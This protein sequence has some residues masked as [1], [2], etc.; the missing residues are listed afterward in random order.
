MGVSENLLSLFIL[1]SLGGRQDSDF[2]ISTQSQYFFHKK[3]F[4]EKFFK[5]SRKSLDNRPQIWYNIRAI[6]VER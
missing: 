2:F 1:R 4:F 5:I 6:R 3:N